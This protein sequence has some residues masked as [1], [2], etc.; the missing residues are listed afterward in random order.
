MSG[1]FNHKLNTIKWIG[2]ITMTID[3]IGYFLFPQ[4]LLLRIIGR[5][6]FP[7]FLYSTIEGTKRTSNY[8]GYISRLVLLGLLSMP[9]TP[10]AINVL[11]LLALFSLSMKYRRFALL[12][13]FLSLFAEYSIYG[14][15]FGWSIYWLKE[16]DQSQGIVLATLVQFLVGL[17]L[18]I[19]ALLSLPLFISKQGLKLPKLPRYF[20]YAYYPL[21][22]LV[23]MIIAMY[24]SS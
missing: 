9:I 12:F 8:R 13:G 5:V 16:K 1:S 18:Q 23:L 2:I 11:F 10:N 17:S 15:V 20:F 3:H 22:Q 7:C 19:F 24:L 21:H 14:F 6:A 4:L